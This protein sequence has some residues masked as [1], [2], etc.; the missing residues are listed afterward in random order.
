MG[1][2]SKA[3]SL[4]NIFSHDQNEIGLSDMARLARLN[5]ATTY[6]LLTELQA[7]GFVEQVGSG[8]AYRLGSTVLRLA[9]LRE[10]HVPLASIARNLVRKLSDETSET[11]HMSLVQGHCLNALT[12]AYSSAHATKVMMED[13]EVLAFHATSSG[14]AILAF[15]PESF[16]SA[17]LSAPMSAITPATI[18]DPQ[19]LRTLFDEIRH[20]GLAESIGGFEADVHSNSA[21]VFG[22]DGL[23]IGAV[24]VAA[25]EARVTPDTR[26]SIREAVKR[27]AAQ[28][29]TETGGFMPAT[30]PLEAAA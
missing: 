15:M 11:A 30:Y 23:P 12:Y 6:R 19:K 13:A 9:A 14:L 29:T 21:P 1:T 8:R 28:L 5:K 17:I 22:P 4:L 2:V 20:S 25:P 7:E 3:L 18:T 16:V 27:T 26:V 24:A 10:A